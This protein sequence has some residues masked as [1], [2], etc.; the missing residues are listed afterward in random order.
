ML[1]ELTGFSLINSRVSAPTSL[2]I[3]YLTCKILTQQ[4]KATKTLS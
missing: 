1:L 3:N 2:K 4:S